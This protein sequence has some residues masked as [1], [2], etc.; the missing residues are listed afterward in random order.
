MCQVIDKGYAPQLDSLRWIGKSS[1]IYKKLDD[2]YLFW[3]KGVSL[4][5]YFCFQS[6][7]EYIEDSE[8]WCSDDEVSYETQSK[9]STDLLA[10]A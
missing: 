1:C 2:S 4:S 5:L 7:D 6:S 3:I 9:V 8:E 10:Q